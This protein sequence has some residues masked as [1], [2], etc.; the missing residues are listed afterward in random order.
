MDITDGHGEDK[1]QRIVSKRILVRLDQFP[2]NPFHR[3]SIVIF[4]VVRSYPWIAFSVGIVNGPKAFRVEVCCRVIAEEL[5]NSG[6]WNWGW[7]RSVFHK[8]VVNSVR[9]GVRYRNSQVDGKSF[10]D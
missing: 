6:P 10:T 2:V 8:R 5:C 3:Y 7:Q 1:M 9:L 4:S